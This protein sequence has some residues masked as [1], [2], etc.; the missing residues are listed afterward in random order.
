M[1]LAHKSTSPQAIS[2]NREFTRGFFMTPPP[3][4][5]G[6]HPLL[7]GGGKSRGAD[8]PLEQKR[9]KVSSQAHKSTSLQVHKLTSQRA[10]TSPNR[11]FQSRYDQTK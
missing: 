6:G 5:K 7:A 3:S 10:A 4:A 1:G 2:P 8:A 9:L 11:D